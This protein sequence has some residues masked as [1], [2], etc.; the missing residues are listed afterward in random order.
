MM[1]ATPSHRTQLSTLLKGMCELPTALDREVTGIE[2]DSRRIAPGA[3]FMAYKG[4]VADGRQFIGAAIAK[5][6]S[7]VLVDADNQWQVCTEQQSVPVVPL[8]NL[9]HKLHLLAARF[10]GEPASNMRLI[11]ITGT[12]GKTTCCQLMAALLA[13]LGYQCGHIGTLGYGMTGAAAETNASGPGTTPD[14][15]RLQHIL[16]LLHDEK[17]DTVVMEVSSHGLQQQRVDIDDF[18]VA[19]FTNLS[20]DHLDFH[21]SLDEYGN[22]KR[23]LFTGKKLQ[24]AILNLDDS[25]SIGT[26]SVLDEALPCYTWSKANTD[27][28][29]YAGS[30]GFTPA[31]IEMDVHT[32]WGEFAI[33]SPLLGS[34]NASNLLGVLCAVLACESVSADFNP[35]KI[36]SALQQLQPVT[37][38]MQLLGSYPVTV[39]VDYAHTPDGLEKALSAVRE[40]CTGKVYCVF[41]CGGERDKGKRPQMGA[42]A[43]Q[44]ADH[45]ILTDDNPR[46]EDSLQIIGQI[47]AGIANKQQVQALPDRAQALALAIDLAQPGDVVL[48]AGKG[49]ETWQEKA[50]QKL[51][52]SDADKAKQLLA[53]RFRTD[54]E[55]SCK[56]D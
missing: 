34:F 52:F 21:G 2:L 46:S 26:R 31:G 40:H 22:V 7:A 53:A 20:R 16:A 33:A 25:Y 56:G 11:G 3:L 54:M 44:L 4:E 55:E 32:P 37:G 48:I 9:Q 28:D 5:G 23:R 13:K 14:A 49:H 42:I 29:V 30:I 18:A 51:P 39:V 50:G 17:A 24:A 47:L 36:V 6:A 27:A 35:Q 19:M 38:R 12:N 10:Y 41:G 15:V 1:L 45:I 43:E 8:H